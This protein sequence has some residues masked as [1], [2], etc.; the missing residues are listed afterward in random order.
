MS[1]II[2]NNSGVSYDVGDV[3]KTLAIGENYTIPPT[4]YL[5][6]AASSDAVT[7]IGAGELIV[8]DGST[9]LSISNGVDLVKG[10]FPTSVE[11]NVTASVLPTGASTSSLQNAL[12]IRVGGLTESTPASDTASSGLNGRLQRIAQRLTSIFTAQSDG[13]QQSK[14]RGNTDATLIGNNLDRLKTSVYMAD[15]P[16]IDSFGRFRV[17]NPTVI[18]DAQFTDSAKDFIFSDVTATGGSESRNDTSGDIEL[19][20]TSS[21]GSRALRQTKEYL[22]YTPGQSLL[23]FISGA[24]GSAKANCKQRFG[25]FD[26]SDGNFFE[27]N[28]T[29]LRVVRRSNVT[30]TPVETAVNQSSWNLDKLDGTGIS[31]ITLDVTKQQI[32]VL[33]LQ[34][35]GSGRIRFG[36]DIGGRVVYCH[37]MNHANILAT[38]Y[39]RRSSLPM[40]VELLNTGATSGS[41]TA[42]ITCMSAVTEGV[43]RNR[44]AVRSFNTTLERGIRTSFEPVIAIRLKSGNIRGNIEPLKV[45]IQATTN[46]FLIWRLLLNASVTGGAWVSAGPNSIAEYNITGTSVSGGDIMDSG[47]VEEDGNTLSHTPEFLQNLSADYAGNSDVMVLIARTDSTSGDV[48]GGLTWKE[49]Y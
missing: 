24:F 32:F 48:L 49:L 20:V 25:F 31:G 13:T 29:T 2:K 22:R 18:F 34:W 41:T 26:D 14:I 45:A 3:G 19:S 23:V 5:L 35:L 30:G 42:H 47:F 28:G 38:K 9:D 21:S 44:V 46:D 6:W 16:S 10:I 36:F 8:N 4:D 40:R 15:S 7:G 27:L 12:S 39:S 43:A 1:K 37:E 17:S 33:D 11:A